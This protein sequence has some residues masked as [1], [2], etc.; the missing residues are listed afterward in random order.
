MGG[1]ADEALRQRNARKKAG[2]G[3]EA[4]IA[5]NTTS[6]FRRRRAEHMCG[7]WVDGKG[8]GRVWDRGSPV[9]V[10]VAEADCHETKAAFGVC[11]R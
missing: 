6:S 9:G 7:L 5:P 11:Y 3:S 4:I 2:L 10:R 8:I 1:C